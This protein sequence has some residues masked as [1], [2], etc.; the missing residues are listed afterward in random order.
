MYRIICL[1][2]A[3]AW[4]TSAHAQA[5]GPASSPYDSARF[6]LF[7]PVPRNQLR[8]L[9]P[10]RPGVT[11]SPFT[12]DAGHLQVETDIL[13]LINRRD[14]DKRE[15][16]WKAAYVTAKL[17]L[18]RRTDVQLEAPLY[19]VLK[20]RMADEPTWRSN[21]GFGDLSVRLKH[22][23]IGDDQE[24]P[25]AVA[26]V[27]FVR[28]PTGGAAGSGGVEGGVVL[29]VDWHIGQKWNLETQLIADVNYDRDAAE[30]F[31]RVMPSV[32]VDYEVNDKL[33]LLL[34][35]VTKWDAQ[36]SGWRS[37][38]NV[39]P[40]INFTDNLQFDFG[41]HFALNREMDRE[42]FVG[43]TVRR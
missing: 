42:F 20:E 26:V 33:S 18:W 43:F 5:S 19:T 7:K 29:P 28:L 3:L 8:E 16:Q 24:G 36:H 35:G 22:N 12:V 32:A 1:L 4:C 14:D 15:R 40:I 39:A 25:V 6:H 10:D 41:G 30:H 13:R 27:G 31:L 21:R 17:G 23:F 38:I 37:S 34:E 9:R 2:A 11:E